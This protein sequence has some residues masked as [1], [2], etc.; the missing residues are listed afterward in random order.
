[1]SPDNECRKTPLYQWHKENGGQIVDFAGW[2]MPV[3][4]ASGVIKE[5]L[6]TRKY[7]GLY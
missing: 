3:Q 4:Y 7:G 5:H 2:D 1:M 6:A